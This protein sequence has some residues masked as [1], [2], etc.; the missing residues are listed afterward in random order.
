AGFLGLGNLFDGE[1][2][3]QNKFKTAY[4]IFTAECTHKHSKGDKVHLL[5]RPLSADA[6]ANVVSGVVTDVIFQHDCFKVILD[7]GIYV[8]LE[9]APKVGQKISAQVKVE[10]LV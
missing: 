7:N 8:Y 10:C 3:A 9:A 4:G 5:A 1:V 2:V 6:D